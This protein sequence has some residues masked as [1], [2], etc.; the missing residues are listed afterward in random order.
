MIFLS[1]FLHTPHLPSHGFGMSDALNVKIAKAFLDVS[2]AHYP[3]RLGVFMIVGECSDSRQYLDLDLDLDLGSHRLSR[4]EK[5]ASF[6]NIFYLSL[7]LSHI[8]Y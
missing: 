7:T 6:I 3:E 1:H 2:G 5:L 8:S 4:G